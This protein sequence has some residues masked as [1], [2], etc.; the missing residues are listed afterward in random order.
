[1]DMEKFKKTLERFADHLTEAG[2]KKAAEAVKSIL[3]AT[4]R[5]IFDE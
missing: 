4:E 5:G 1:M 3:K 2:E